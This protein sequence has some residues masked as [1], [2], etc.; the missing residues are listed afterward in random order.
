[1]SNDTAMIPTAT[2]GN[3]LQPT[4]SAAIA[5]AEQSKATVLA[6]YQMA[7]MRPRNM[8]QVRRALLRECERP[9]LAEVAEYALP[10]RDKE[11]N[12]KWIKGPSI[13]LA[14][15]VARALGNIYTE[16]VVIAEDDFTRTVRVTVMDLE[17]NISFSGDVVCR[18]VA[19]RRRLMED[20]EYISTRVNSEGRTVYVVAVSE[21]EQLQQQN[22]AISR[23]LRN[24][25]LRLLPGGLLDEAIQKCRATQ[26]KQD[27]ADPDAHRHRLVDAFA[28]LGIEP[29]DLVEY[30]G[31]PLDECTPETISN[32]RAVCTSIRDGQVSW[33]TIVEKRAHRRSQEEHEQ[34]KPR[35]S[36]ASQVREKVQARRSTKPASKKK[37]GRQT[38]SR[39]PQAPND[40]TPAAKDAPTDSVLE[41]PRIGS[42]DDGVTRWKEWRQS[43]EPGWWFGEWSQ[44]DD[45]RSG[46]VLTNGADV[47]YES[48]DDPNI[49]VVDAAEWAF[50]KDE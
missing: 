43:D 38:K 42:G 18:K 40:A 21:P 41:T 3:M 26:G 45:D 50:A 4:S 24:H 29:D 12:K 46:V 35:P 19:E 39:P 23:I 8:D 6:R 30:L 48:G 2:A 15:V 11:G 9:S 14:E 36:K 49:A 5:L 37:G 22:A 28:E 47:K 13:R 17:S 27:K 31:Y 10:R 25:I 44:P 33:A 32:L 16:S 20:Q 1:M 7:L 34:K